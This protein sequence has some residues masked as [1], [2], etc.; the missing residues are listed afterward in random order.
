MQT[1]SWMEASLAEMMAARLWD[2]II[3]DQ[4]LGFVEME[5]ESDDSSK[6]KAISLNFIS[7]SSSVL[8]VEDILHISFYI[9]A[10]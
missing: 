9:V 3:M 10:F 2:I 6:V 8:M 7:R 1:Q 5:L 4:R